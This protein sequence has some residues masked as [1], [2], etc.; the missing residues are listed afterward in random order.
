VE[1]QKVALGAGA[2]SD[3]KPNKRFKNYNDLFAS[4]TKSKNVVTLYPVVSMI[5]TYNSKYAVTVTKKNDRTYFVKMYSLETYEVVFE[6]MIGGKPES[7]IKLKEVE[8]NAAG[9]KYA[10]VYL[11]DGRFYLRYFGASTRTPE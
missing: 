6:E 8:Q 4:L 1:H 5:I 2:D 11:D 10:F 7:Y 9:T 3:V